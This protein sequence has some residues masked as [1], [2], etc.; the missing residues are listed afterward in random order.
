MPSF[1]NRRIVTAST[2]TLY[3]LG[4]GTTSTN[5][6]PFPTANKGVELTIQNQSTGS[7]DIWVGGSDLSIEIG[8]TATGLIGG[9]QLSQGASYTVGKRH[10]PT[11]IILDE[12]YICSTS[13]RAVAQAQLLRMV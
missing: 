4:T 13:S 1:T 5:T 11:A 3:S 12:W 9:V 6:S 10:A 7:F 8:S 2:S